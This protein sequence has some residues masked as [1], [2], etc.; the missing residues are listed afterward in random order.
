M[1]LVN[2]CLPAA[3]L[4]AG[5]L[6][7]TPALACKCEQMTR[8]QAIA[9]G[10]AAFEGLVVRVRFEGSQTYAEIET[11][12]PLKGAV[13]RRVELGSRRSAAACGVVFREG[14]RLT[15]VARFA[16]QQFTT[17]S[18]LIRAVNGK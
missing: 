13:P 3:V 14:Q 8:A 11:S 1:K 5:G 10:D 12:R 18:C 6:A 17:N 15:F 4:A 7:A 16:E 9:R 2:A